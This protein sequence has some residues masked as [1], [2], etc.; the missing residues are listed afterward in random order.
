MGDGEREPDDRG[1]VRV[2]NGI[3]EDGDNGDPGSFSRCVETHLG[4]PRT[5]ESMV[6]RN[7]RRTA[8]AGVLGTKEPHATCFLKELLVSTVGSAFEDSKV[9]LSEVPDLTESK[10]IVRGLTRSCKAM[11]DSGLG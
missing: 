1:N 3:G 2:I 5:C 10:D 7:V 6:G 11:V 8:V 9:S 4:R